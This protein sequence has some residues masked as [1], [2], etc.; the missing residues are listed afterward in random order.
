MR[1]SDIEEG[2]TFDCANCETAVRFA[3]LD[4]AN[5]RAWQAYPQV[6]SRFALTT[7]SSPAVLARLTVEDDDETALEFIARLAVIFHLLNPV[8][9]HGA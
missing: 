7:R 9:K 2:D 4:A 1:E 8:K 5:L 6:C 3:E